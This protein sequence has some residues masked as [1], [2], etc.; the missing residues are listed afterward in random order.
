MAVKQI[1]CAVYDNAVKAYLTPFFQK[2]R[3][4]ALR[5]FKAAVNDPKHSF[6]SYAADYT[7]FALGEF[8]EETGKFQQY[9]VFDNLGSALEHID[10]DPQPG[11]L[12]L[13]D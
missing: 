4:E 5:N 7:L 2:T 1:V 6:N 11:R 9:E 12:G 8:D 13:V 10:V 3:A